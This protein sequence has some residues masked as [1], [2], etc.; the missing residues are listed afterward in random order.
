MHA[1]A[2]A[3]VKKAKGKKRATREPAKMKIYSQT[4]NKKHKATHNGDSIS[5]TRN[6]ECMERND[7][8]S[9]Y[10][11]R[12]KECMERNDGRSTYQQSKVDF[13]DLCTAVTDLHLVIPP[14][15]VVVTPPVV[16]LPAA[17][18]TPAHSHRCASLKSSLLRR[19]SCVHSWG[20]VSQA[21]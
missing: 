13:L 7:G 4:A 1:L 19:Y 11:Q 18:P 14:P 9:T 12:N 6:K 3:C 20:S 16:Q 5:Q 2:L 8:R 21:I 10:H 15:P 17:R